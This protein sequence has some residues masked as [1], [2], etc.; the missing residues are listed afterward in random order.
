MPKIICIDPGHGGYDPGAFANGLKEKDLN[1]AVALGLKVLLEH[2]GIT[3]IMTRT[4]DEC[5]GGDTTNVAQDLKARCDISDKAK[6]DLFLSI[7]FN[8]GG[9]K[10]AEAYAWPGGTAS[11]FA[12][13]LVAELAPLMGIHGEPLKDGGPNGANL[14]VIKYTEAP[15]ILLE[16]GFIDSTDAQKIKDN[17]SKFPA[18]LA[19]ALIK[20]LGGSVP[21]DV[22]APTVETTL[23]QATVT[24]TDLKA[25]LEAIREEFAA[26][27]SA[28]PNSLKTLQDDINAKILALEAK[29]GG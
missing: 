12:P 2:A 18:L 10:G 15:A 24:Q 16:C 6:A 22:P 1:L 5:P 25:A 13:E 19:P 9:G 7:H 28:L 23:P 3:V 17:L 11:T 26:A 29:I 20:W 27:L 4:S 8:A 14:Y 21:Q